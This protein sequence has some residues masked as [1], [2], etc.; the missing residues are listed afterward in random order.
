MIICEAFFQ[1]IQIFYFVLYM[2]EKKK[3]F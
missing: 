1:L 3:I 2:Q